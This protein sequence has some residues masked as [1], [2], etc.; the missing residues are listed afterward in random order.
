LNSFVL[1]GTWIQVLRVSRF[2]HW[3]FWHILFIYSFQASA[4]LVPQIRLWLLPVLHPFQCNV[5]VIIHCCMICAVEGFVYKL[6]TC[7][8]IL[9]VLYLQVWLSGMWYLVGW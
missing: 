5:Y 1:I 9:T 2:R 7:A 4:G 8:M 3:L 6:R